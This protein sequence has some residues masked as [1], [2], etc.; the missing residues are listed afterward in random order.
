MIRL[1][2][3]AWLLPIDPTIE[4]AI[5]SQGIS[6]GLRQTEGVQVSA[7]AEADVGAIFGGAS[8]K[9]VTSPTADGEANLFGG[10][11]G[12]FG[13][14]DLRASIAYKRNTSAALRSDRDAI[15][16]AATV[17]RTFGRI[18]PRLSLTYSHDDVGATERSL[19]VEVS[20]TVS[21]RSALT[22]SANFGWR[23]RAGGS[24]YMAFNTGLTYALNREF[25]ADV[26][27]YDTSRSSFGEI[28]RHRIVA[29]LRARF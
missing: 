11:R 12:N 3:A 10:V 24:D 16:I 1:G 27:Y 9:N 6:K 18:T 20:S 17:S 19:F 28:Y 25:S 5:A 13:V 15:E 4:I 29:S 14:L 7:R 22:A 23:E 8:Y 2:L 26:R 21:L